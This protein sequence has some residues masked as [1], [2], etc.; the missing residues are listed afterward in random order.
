MEARSAIDDLLEHLERT[1]GLSDRELGRLVDEIREYFS[2]SVEQ[3]VTRRHAELQSEAL[4]NDA[5]FDR[6]ADELRLRRFAAPP[7][8]QRQIRRLVYG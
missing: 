8:T 6:I 3:F 2:E 7:L 1:T 5:I 4:K